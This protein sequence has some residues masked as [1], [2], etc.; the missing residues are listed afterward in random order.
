MREAIC[1]LRFLLNRGYRRKTALDFVSNRYRLDV[2]DRNF[3]VRSVFS[4]EE[5]EE[6]K[7]KLVG[8]EEIKGQRLTIDGYNVIITVE[9]ILTDKEVVLCDDG[10]IRD[11][12]AIF[13][14]HRISDVTERAID[15]IGRVLLE[16]NAKSATFIFDSAVSHSGELCAFTGTKHEELGI[17]TDAR[18]S[19]NADLDVSEGGGI[20][21]TSDRAIIKKTERVFDIAFCIARD[22]GRIKR[23]PTC[24]EIYEKVF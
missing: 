23:L 15:E 18:T 20:I 10:L 11:T 8:I 14:K 24:E 2:K 6:H 3:L 5:A 4:K 13:G 12:S 21:C 16:C 7:R 1:D 22:G 19:P 9:S 17:E